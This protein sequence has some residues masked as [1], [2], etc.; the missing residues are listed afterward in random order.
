VNT[1]AVG[2]TPV[3]SEEGSTTAAQSCVSYSDGTA[4]CV[5]RMQNQ[6]ICSGT[7][8]VMT[9][10]SCS[11]GP[12]CDN[13]KVQCN[14]LATGRLDTAHCAW[15]PWASEELG[16]RLFTGSFLSCPDSNPLNCTACGTQ[17]FCNFF[18]TGVQCRGSNCDDKS[19]RVCPVVP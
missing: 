9:G 12:G 17:T 5:S 8:A 18:A 15:T 1:N 2:W 14:K 7:N 4:P 13:V 10:I 19:F 11:G 16:A 6:G 3:F